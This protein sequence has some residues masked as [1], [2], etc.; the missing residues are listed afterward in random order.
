MASIGRT[1]D[2]TGFFDQ[3]AFSDITIAF[4]SRRR[5]CHKMIL[6]SKSKYFDD[7]FGP[8]KGFAE[9]EQKTVWL[10]GDDED[11]CEAM[12]RWL[13]TF[14]YEE[15]SGAA[16][17]QPEDTVDFHLGVCLV[18]DKYMLQDLLNEA[19]SRLR[20]RLESVDEAELTRIVG[21]VRNADDITLYP[22]AVQA[23][24]DDVRDARLH[25]LLRHPLYRELMRVNHDLCMDTVDKVLEEKLR[26]F[27][28]V[29]AER[30][31]FVCAKCKREA[32]MPA[33]VQPGNYA[34]SNYRCARTLTSVEH[35]IVWVKK[36]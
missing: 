25:S 36:G 12:L 5:R 24:V 20:M 8:G 23:L 31:Y 1:F 17:A 3:E 6:C 27:A 16:D 30:S 14:D 13:Y 33:T 9:A 26:G 19:L 7:L 34:C 32:L 2:V 11:A 21:D 22:Q 10:E 18:A 35:Q 4:G 15:R 29:V 28:S